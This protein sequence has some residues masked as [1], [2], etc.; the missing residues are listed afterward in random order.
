VAI[1]GH[2][3]RSFAVTCYN[4]HSYILI[5]ALG[6]SV[7]VLRKTEA[8]LVIAVTIERSA[9][10]P[11]KIDGTNIVVPEE[12]V[13]AIPVYAMHHDAQYFPEP[14]KFDPERFSDENLSSIRPYTY[15]PFG[16]GPRN[17]VGMRFALHAV[18]LCLM[19]AIHCARFVRTP[20]T[21]VPLSF[22]QGFGVLNAKDI[23][24][25]VRPLDSPP[26]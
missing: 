10:E 8:N 7:S 13:V 26:N 5:G 1:A 21:Q 14:E 25:G 11:Y 17:C 20:E 4:L 22:Y 9:T 6:S 2:H 3:R 12:G 15:L 18:K 19:N 16:A 24:I 23:A